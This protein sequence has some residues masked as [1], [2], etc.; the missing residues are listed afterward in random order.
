MP[1]KRA[2]KKKGKKRSGKP[3]ADA[4]ALAPAID[5]ERDLS[6]PDSQASKMKAMLAAHALTS[7]ERKAESEAVEE[8][9]AAAGVST[10]GQMTVELATTLV[11]EIDRR[12][13]ARGGGL[14][15]FPDL[16]RSRAELVG[17]RAALSAINLDLTFTPAQLEEIMGS[18]LAR[19]R[20]VLAAQD[21]AVSGRVFGAVSPALTEIG[22]ATERANAELCS[23]SESRTLTADHVAFHA[24]FLTQQREKLVIAAEACQK[25]SKVL[26]ALMGRCRD[27][28]RV[29]RYTAEHGHI[30][31]QFEAIKSDTVRFN[32]IL[33]QFQKS[34]AYSKMLDS[35]NDVAVWTPSG[36]LVVD[37]NK[38]GSA[39]AMPTFEELMAEE[40]GRA[41][42]S[43]G[44]GGGAQAGGGGGAGGSDGG[45]GGFQG[46]AGPTFAE[47]LEQE[48][49]ERAKEAPTSRP[50]APGMPPALLQTRASGASRSGRGGVA[51]VADDAADAAARAQAKVELANMFRMAEE[52]GLALGGGGAQGG[53]GGAGGGGFQDFG[54]LADA[55]DD[56][57]DA[58]ARA[59]AKV[60][61]ANMFRMLSE[62]AD[63]AELGPLTTA[64]DASE[65]DDDFDDDDVGA[66]IVL[67]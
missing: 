9:M 22:R 45:G 28:S 47:L 64:E 21:A 6:N 32:L 43:P 29:A 26:A 41:S 60:E 13:A 61:L 46:F 1:K 2:K 30:K 20:H 56:A 40:R 52:R 7:N 37:P 10:Q 48:K 65:D 5:P 27:R 63:L 44:G 4:A 12:V 31:R 33:Q 57:A 18:E 55:A 17:R 39:D 66:D 59:Q 67:D 34:P 25:R 14:D 42:G 38:D 3:K 51:D 16:K 58:A 36:A 11:D 15:A 8:L 24:A 19:A 35:V 23:K 49:A 62:R 53:D 54:G 50:A